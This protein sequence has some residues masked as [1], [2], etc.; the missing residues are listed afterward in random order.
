MHTRREEAQIAAIVLCWAICPVSAR[1]SDY[2]IDVDCPAWRADAAAQVEARVRTTLLAEGLEAHQ[3][4]IAC[5]ASGTIEVAVRSEHGALLV[6]VVRRAERVE[7]DVVRTVE[8]ALRQL[9]PPPPEPEP[10]PEPPASVLPPPAPPAAAVPPVLPRPAPVP[11]RE[12]EVAPAVRTTELYVSSTGELWGKLAALGADA[13]LSV[14]TRS[15]GYGLALGARTALGEAD[16]FE[17]NEL[18]GSIRIAFT[19][20]SPLGLRL[21]FGAGA[22]L[23][24]TSPSSSLVA[25]SPTLLGAACFEAKVSRPFWFGDIALSPELGAR[26]FSANRNVVVDTREE[27]VVPVVVPQVALSARYRY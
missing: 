3:V 27:A 14:G 5:T 22:S 7:D 1:A 12:L 17:L 24:M 19:S 10:E 11:R 23:L 13:G 8:G 4:S 18:S 25:G 20:R 9:I 15:V 6:P 26:L 21:T 16:T 2:P